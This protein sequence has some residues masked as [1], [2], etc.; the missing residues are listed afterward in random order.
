VFKPYI[1][2]IEIYTRLVELILRQL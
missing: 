2:G 1:T